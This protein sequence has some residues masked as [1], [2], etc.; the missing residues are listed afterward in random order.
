MSSKCVSPAS[1]DDWNN[2]YNND[3]YINNHNKLIDISFS[4]DLILDA[5][6]IAFFLD[7]AMF[8]L[9]EK[10]FFKQF[11][12]YFDSLRICYGLIGAKSVKVY[13]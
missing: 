11:Q 2:F 7:L 4:A 3:D 8:N 12:L 13:M 10:A 6:S 1:N 9:D 5:I